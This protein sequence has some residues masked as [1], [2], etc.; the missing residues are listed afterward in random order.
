MQESF[1]Q[2][3]GEKRRRILDAALWEFAGHDY[4]AANTESIAHRA[5][6]SKGALFYY[7][8]NKEALY[9]TLVRYA[10]HLVDRGM[11]MQ[12]A[13]PGEDLFA[14][15]D[16]LVD[17][18][19]ELLRKMPVIVRFSVRVYYDNAFGPR[20]ALDRFLLRYTDQMYDRY[21]AGVAADR[22]KPGFTPR[23][24]LDWLIYMTDGYLHAERMAGRELDIDALFVNYRLWQEMVRRTMYREDAL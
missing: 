15:L 2:L 20:E 5:G 21:L 7:F 12:P 4:K 6:I 8:R 22:F 18:K 11:A 13:A 16:K 10:G 1:R 17:K 3:P 19:A 24:A 23:Q 9:L 14:Y